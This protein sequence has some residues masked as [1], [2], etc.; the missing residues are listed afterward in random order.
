MILRDALTGGV[1]TVF[2]AVV[3]EE[4]LRM[5]RY[6]NLG[7]N[8]YTAPG[9]VP[10]V[11]GGAIILFG[12]I[13][14]TRASGVFARRAR[15][16]EVGAPPPSG[17]RDEASGAAGV[18]ARSDVTRA[19]GTRAVETAAD[20]YGHDPNAHDPNGQDPE[21]QDPDGSGAGGTGAGAPPALAPRAASY[22]LGLTLLLTLVYAGVLVGRL[23]FALATFL[24]VGGFIVV[25]EWRRGPAAAAARRIAIAV[26][27]AALVAVAVSFVF[28]RI[29]LVR[30]P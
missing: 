6:E 8:P 21:G 15:P 19:A 26:F 29:F 9:I 20:E 1:L 4:S 16:S 22:R 5:P 27:E 3:L 18:E 2:G 12:L 28:E 30:L 10:A 23:P 14:F 25:F 24:F 7:V 17:A 11:L 13:M